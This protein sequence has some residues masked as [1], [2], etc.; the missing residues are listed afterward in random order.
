MI[1]QSTALNYVAT[2]EIPEAQVTS[3]ETVEADAPTSAAGQVQ[4][5]V[6]GADI[7]T[8]AKGV[9]ADQ[10]QDIVNST[11][12]AQLAANKAGTGDVQIWYAKYFDVLTNIGWVIADRSFAN[13]VD[14][15]EN[16][17]AHEA[18]KRIAATLLGSSPAAL[19]LITGTLDALKAASDNSPW[20]TL[21]NRESQSTSSKRFQMTLVEPN[22]Q[23][24]DPT[25]AMMMFTL[26]A[27]AK[28]T[29][30]L[31]FKFANNSVR[32]RHA[33]G[34][35]TINN[36]VLQSVR[37]A[38]EQRLAAYAAHFVKAIEL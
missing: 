20:I 14:E 11:L 1:T 30:V 2:L 19:S 32:F 24:N 13:Y 21:L 25:I 36:A 31:F 6:A 35:V 7:V 5:L 26:E 38:I 16:F 15:S 9:P 27:D 17:Q 37:T 4:A 10:R 34:K 29:Q 18:I 8:F 33:S 28:L 23:G 3:V 12:L 22:P